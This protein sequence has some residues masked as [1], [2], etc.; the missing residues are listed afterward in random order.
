MS[1][2]IAFDELLVEFDGCALLY[3]LTFVYNLSKLNASSNPRAYSGLHHNYSISV[4]FV[5]RIYT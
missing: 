5:V 2:K 1:V 4:M 3:V